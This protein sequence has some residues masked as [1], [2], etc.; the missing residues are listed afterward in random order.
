MTLIWIFYFISGDH[1]LITKIVTN[2]H[3]HTCTSILSSAVKLV[4][5]IIKEMDCN[6]KSKNSGGTVPGSI[7]S[8]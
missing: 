8:L 3:L 2:K 5:Y 1:E 4:D 6:K 7:K